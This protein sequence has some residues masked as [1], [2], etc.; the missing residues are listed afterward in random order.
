MKQTGKKEALILQKLCDTDP[1][2]KYNNIKLISQ[3][4]DR[5]HLCLV[6]E[7]MDLNLRQ[8]TKKYGGVGLNI[9]AVRIYAF[10]LLKALLHLK[11]NTIIHADFKPD[12]ILINKSRTV[13][14]LADLGSAMFVEEAEPTPILVS[15]FYRAPEII[16]GVNYGTQIDMFAFGCCLF[17]LATGK[18]LLRSSDNNQHLKLLFEIKSLPPKKMLQ[19]AKFREMHFDDA[20]RFLEHSTDP[21]TSKEIVR[22]SE[23]SKPTRFLIKDLMNSYQ[24]STFAEKKHITRLCD[25]IEKC[26]EIDPA[27]RI[28]PEQALRH[29]LFKN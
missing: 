15:R 9:G 1:D 5:D 17:E 26:I 25:L 22:V 14:K 19:R 4:E 21:T 16:L 28:E 11:R 7:P 27:K 6:F 8:L 3:F 10:K 24:D 23:I 2:N 13:I 18:P 20:L 29:S 12:N